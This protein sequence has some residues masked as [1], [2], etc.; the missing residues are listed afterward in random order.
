M[1]TQTISPKRIADYFFMVGLRDDFSLISEPKDQ[2]GSN[3][4]NQNPNTLQQS[5]ETDYHP[6]PQADPH[7]SLFDGNTTKSPAM[8][9]SARPSP[10]D[11]SSV[12]VGGQ[13]SGVVGQGTGLAAPPF[14]SNA[15][16]LGTVK[17]LTRTRSKS[18]AQFH[19]HKPAV[20]AL[21]QHHNLET[22]IRH[23]SKQFVL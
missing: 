13:R 14:S 17:S 20:P 6:P 11:T 16:D 19:Y 15:V 21:L 10:K 22:P 18:V 4:Q 2:P 9:L 1:P 8:N 12:K 5:H 23:N 3:H 7:S